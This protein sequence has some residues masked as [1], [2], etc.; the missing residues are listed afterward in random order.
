M[1]SVLSEPVFGESESYPESNK[2]KVLDSE[3]LQTNEIKPQPIN[4]YLYGGDGGELK[5]D[6]PLGNSTTEVMCQGN[7]F[8]RTAGYYIGSWTS[9]E[10]TAPITIDTRISCGLWVYSME[11]ANNVRFNVELQINGNGVFTFTTGSNSVSQTPIEITGEGNSNSVIELQVGDTIGIRLAYFSDP[12]YVIGPGADATLITGDIEYDSHIT[13]ITNPISLNLD[14]PIVTDTD[15]TFSAYFMDTFSSTNLNADLQ[16]IGKS[17]VNTLSEPAFSLGENG[18]LVSW[19]WDH[20]TDGAKDGEYRIR[21]SI[22]YS[23][24][25]DFSASGI[26]LIE[27]PKD[28]KDDDFLGGIFWIL[29]VMIL[30]AIAI[31]IIITVRKRLSKR[32]R[33]TPA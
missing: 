22:Y 15:V 9:L 1:V 17:E 33:K 25:N 5:P 10:V 29:P 24:E 32:G 11:G 3:Y 26:Y 6:L 19:I 18:S 8:A 30:T 2:I 20:K 7:N 14:V 4:M 31:T 21:I 23:E 27:F 13:I 12:I 16:V 28:K